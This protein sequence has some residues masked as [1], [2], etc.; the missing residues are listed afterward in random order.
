MA[1][2]VNKFKLNSVQKQYLNKMLMVVIAILIGSITTIISIYQGWYLLGVVAVVIALVIIK[3]NHK[4]AIILKAGAKGEE[5][6]LKL[7]KGLPSNCSV[8]WDIK[9][10]SKSSTAQIDYLII[11]PYKIFIL[12]AKNISGVLSGKSSDNNL[13]Q[14]KERSGETKKPYNPLL[15]VTKHG[16][17]VKSILAEQDINCPVEYGVYFSNKNLKNQVDWGNNNIFFLGEEKEMLK[18]L[19][20]AKTAR[21]P[22]DGKKILKI[23]K[24]F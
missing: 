6:T 12:E 20:T 21:K 19:S 23:L 4:K 11:S 10:S 9:V 24:N 8:M 7:L 13:T 1:K 5:T 22:I 16:Q 2:I 3:I 15:Q 18:K 14:Y 17:V